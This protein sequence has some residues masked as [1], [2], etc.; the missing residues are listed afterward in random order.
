MARTLKQ[1]LPFVLALLLFFAAACSKE[2]SVTMLNTV[3]TI[4]CDGCQIETTV[5]ELTV[6]GNQT[7]ARIRFLNLGNTTLDALNALVEFVDADGNVIATYE[8]QLQFDESLAVGDS[9]SATA[10]CERDDRIVGVVVSSV[11]Y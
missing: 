4:Y 9:V 10:R 2:P 8:V 5:R 1:S 11:T 7:T 3:D 6:D